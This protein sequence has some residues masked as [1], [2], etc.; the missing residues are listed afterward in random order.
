MGLII[1]W[2]V[3]GGAVGAAV[4]SFMEGRGGSL[5]LAWSVVAGIVGAL[6]GGFVFM[7]I[8]TSL[9]G[10]GPEFVVSFLAAAILAFIAVIAARAIKR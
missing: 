10:P 7:L 4:S 1:I 8:G 5:N 6:I 2:V 3:I 9:V